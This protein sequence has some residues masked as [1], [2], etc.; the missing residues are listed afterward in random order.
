[1]VGLGHGAAEEAPQHPTAD[2]QNP[3]LTADTINNAVSLEYQMYR[4][5]INDDIK[6][7]SAK[8]N[9]SRYNV[10]INAGIILKC[11]TKSRYTCNHGYIRD[12]SNAQR[13]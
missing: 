10:Q 11:C 13:L 4:Y 6:L 2:V 9:N 8:Y 1:M 5:Y 7:Q 12:D 3:R